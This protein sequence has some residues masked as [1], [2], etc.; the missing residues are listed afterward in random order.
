MQVAALV[1]RLEKNAK[2]KS[3]SPKLAAIPTNTKTP[4][5]T[6]LPRNPSMHLGGFMNG[7]SMNT[8]GTM[9]S[10]D[11][12]GSISESG[13]FSKGLRRD[14]LSSSTLS[15]AASTDSSESDCTVRGNGDGIRSREGVVN[16]LSESEYSTRPK[17][18]VLDSAKKFETIAE[19]VPDGGGCAEDSCNEATGVSDADILMSEEIFGKAF[20]GGPQAAAGLVARLE[21]EVQRSSCRGGG[22]GGGCTQ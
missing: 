19:A 11:S 8:L 10:M 2:L 6:Y 17:D 3:N 21:R 22:V 16:A 20:R 4:L 18:F 5:E 7:S 14:G 1:S 15:T 13:T 9:T 12:S